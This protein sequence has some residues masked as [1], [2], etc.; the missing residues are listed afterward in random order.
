MQCWMHLMYRKYIPFF[1]KNKEKNIKRLNDFY[2][3]H[4]LFN[5][6]KKN[7]LRMQLKHLDCFIVWYWLKIWNM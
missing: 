7:L 4:F 3:N 6:T 5:F 2:V 1:R